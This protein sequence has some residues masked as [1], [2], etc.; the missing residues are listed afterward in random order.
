MYVF[1]IGPIFLSGQ[2]MCTWRR[3][4]GF[5]SQSV[6]LLQ[7]DA[8]KKMFSFH[9]D[10]PRM[11]CQLKVIIYSFSSLSPLIRYWMAAYKCKCSIPSSKQTSMRLV[12]PCGDWFVG[13]CMSS[14]YCWMERKR[15]VRE[16]CLWESVSRLLT[17]PCL[18]TGSFIPPKVGRWLLH[19]RL[20]CHRCR[21]R[22]WQLNRL[23][24][25]RKMLF[26]QWRAQRGFRILAWR[27]IWSRSQNK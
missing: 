22:S 19:F 10:H 8:F 25:V 6:D 23:L 9:V 20:Y 16:L 24:R 21:R 17:P 14:I 7:F 15:S 1:I 2:C 18:P 13:G 12:W 4:P 5:E 26:K 11:T 3:R 27:W